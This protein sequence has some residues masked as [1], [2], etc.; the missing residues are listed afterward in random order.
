MVEWYHAD[1]GG[2]HV[3]GFRGDDARDHLDQARLIGETVR[4]YITP[5][6]TRWALDE[7][8]SRTLEL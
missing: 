8:K 2:L 7:E 4:A 5:R 1:K 3:R 6:W